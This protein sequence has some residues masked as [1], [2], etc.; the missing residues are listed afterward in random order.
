M[1]KLNNRVFLE[2]GKKS[3][4]FRYENMTDV[5]RTMEALK[6]SLEEHMKTI[7]LNE[8]SF[9]GISKFIDF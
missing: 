7:R 8:S 4:I 2:I 5:I 9:A 6:G 3:Q 1:V